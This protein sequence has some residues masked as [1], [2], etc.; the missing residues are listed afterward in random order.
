MTRPVASPS[1]RENLIGRETAVARYIAIAR[2][3]CA[4]DF[5]HAARGHLW[6]AY[7]VYRMAYRCVYRLT[8]RTI[9]KRLLTHLISIVA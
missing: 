8:V 3:P 1:A 5:R 6:Y 9:H 2:V 4:Y 7:T